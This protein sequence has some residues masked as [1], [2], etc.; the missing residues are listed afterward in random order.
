MDGWGG[1]VGR[2]LEVGRRCP[3][4]FV[5]FLHDGV[6]VHGFGCLPQRHGVPF[7]HVWRLLLCY[8]GVVRFVCRF[9][10]VSLQG[11]RSR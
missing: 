5:L 10:H 7:G 8:F 3:R 11:Q 6:T 9:A 1:A 2:G 4:R